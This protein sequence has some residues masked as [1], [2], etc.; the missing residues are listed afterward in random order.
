[1]IKMTDIIFP[2]VLKLPIDWG[3]LDYFRHINN[4]AYYKY[5]QASRVKYL[6]KIGL[7][8]M[9]RK[10][11]IGPILASCK[12]DFKKP[13]FY[14]GQVIVHSRVDLIKNT[15]ISIYH[16]I[17]DDKNIIVA[18]AQDIIVVYDFIKDKKTALPEKIRKRIEKL[19]NKTF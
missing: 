14:P 16:K 8:Q 12:C 4:I 19:E 7:M 1:M 15:S 17:M 3:D 2:V 9:H 10:T 11:N 18:E 5:I 13:L 6:E